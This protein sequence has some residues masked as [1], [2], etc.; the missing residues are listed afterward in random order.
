VLKILIVRS[1]L[2]KNHLKF[3]KVNI[4]LW[5]LLKSSRFFFCQIVFQKSQS[6]IVRENPGLIPKWNNF[7][8]KLY[9]PRSWTIDYHNSFLL[10]TRELIKKKTQSIIP[11]NKI[12]LFEKIFI[13]LEIY[14]LFLLYLFLQ[15]S[16]SRP[17]SC[18]SNC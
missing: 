15:N 11:P 18:P 3:H 6:K 16:S 13:F 7:L 2:K 1:L 10:K 4:I 8:V 12:Y 5:N 17:L 14:F 9:L